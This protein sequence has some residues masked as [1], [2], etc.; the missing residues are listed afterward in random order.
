MKKFRN[1]FRNPTV[2]DKFKIPTATKV[3]FS[4]G[5]IGFN[6]SAGLF[7]AWLYNF[8]I[9]IVQIDPIFWALAWILYIVWNAIND[10]L[11]G[12]FGDQTRTRYGRRMPWLMIATPLIS[13][14]FIFLF[15]P[16]LLNPANPISQWLFFVWLFIWL[17]M[18]DSF[19]T[20]IGITQKALVAELTILPEERANTTFFW[21][22]GTLVGQVITFLIPFLFIIN[23]DPYSQNLPT[24]Q[25]MVI[26][27]GI[28][29]IFL[30]AAM[31]FGI[32]ER[33]EFLF[34][35]KKK[36]KFLDSIKQTIKNRAF[37]IYTIFSFT[38]VYI[39]FSIY[40]QVSFFVQDV[41]E[42]SSE[43]PLS[44]LPLIIFI[45]A[46][47][48]GYPIGMFFNRKYGGKKGLIY[49]SGFVIS[50]LVF[51]TFAPE[52]ISSNIAL[53]IVG[54]SYSGMMLIAPI[55]MADVIDK[56]EL[57]TGRRREGAYY[58][59]NNLFTKPAQSIAA[60]LTAMV[61]A[62]TGYN[63]TTVFQ[64]DLA[65]FGIKLNIGLIPAIFI[66]IGII[67]LLKFPIDASTE[68]Y[69]NWKRRVEDLHEKKIQEYKKSLEN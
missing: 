29:G 10:P 9:K 32:E 69:K 67:V 65:Q 26:I 66:T 14:S 47:L 61:L 16:P 35:E 27:F 58:G 18:Y 43:N 62:L 40:S 2:S 42:I 38:L 60:A 12:F 15:F 33:K 37:I 7:A 44:T 64:D 31:S 24:I 55:L 4:I 50:G 22:L 11:I 48:V 25:A 68:E 3:K 39:N 30:L 59:T 53:L 1:L 56:D 20:I 41:L 13:I 23:K 5:G 8:Y 51:L 45:G 28:I 6:L 46:S 17:L 21:S 19:Y 63:Q 34:A 57:K 49:L 36:M 54:F 52:F